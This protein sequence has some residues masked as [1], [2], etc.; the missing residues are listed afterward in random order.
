MASQVLDPWFNPIPPMQGPRALCSSHRER[1][2]TPGPAKVLRIP[3]PSQGRSPFLESIL[4]P[5]WCGSSPHRGPSVTSSGKHFPAR[6][7]SLI[8]PFLC[9]RLKS[10]IPAVGFLGPHPRQ[11]EVLRLGVEWELQL[12]AY[13]TATAMQDLSHICDLHHSSQRRQILNPLSEASG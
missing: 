12:P 11:V 5:H 2:P 3:K 9:H 10:P 4:S 13:T 8:H 6:P 7:G 1:L